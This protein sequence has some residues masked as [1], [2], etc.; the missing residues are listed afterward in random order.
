M[1]AQLLFP[2]KPQ[3][4]IYLLELHNMDSSMGNNMLTRVVREIK[5]HNKILRGLFFF[6]LNFYLG[7]KNNLIYFLG[8]CFPQIPVAVA[9]TLLK[10]KKEQGKKDH[11]LLRRYGFYLGIYMSLGSCFHNLLPHVFLKEIITYNCFTSS[12][13][14]F[15]T[16]QIWKCHGTLLSFIAQLRWREN[17]DMFIWQALEMRIICLLYTVLR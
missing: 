8:R 11:L 2:K 3:L 15:S 17:E 6:P 13:T 10:K 14:P 1:K 7:P 5:I 4:H 12:F 16:H 9:A